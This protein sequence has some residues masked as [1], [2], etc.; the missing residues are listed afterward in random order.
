MRLVAVG[1]KNWLHCGSDKGAERLA[2]IYTV[3]VTANNCGADLAAGLAW[4][5]DKLGRRTYTVEEARE[6]LPDK[7]PKANPDFGRDPAGVVHSVPAVD[8]KIS[9]QV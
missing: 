9:A 8:I 1:R 2:D 6:L 4:V 7:W 3:L 5:F